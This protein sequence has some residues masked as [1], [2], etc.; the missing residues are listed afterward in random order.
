MSALSKLVAKLRDQRGVAAVEATVSV[1]FAVAFIG[2]GLAFTYTFLA[3]LW[4][5]NSAYEASI[6][7]S[8]SQPQFECEQ[9]LKKRLKGALTLGQL[10][11][12][13]LQ[14]SQQKVKT[15]IA[16]KTPAGLT[17]RIDDQRDLPLL[18]K[19]GVW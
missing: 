7:L 11:H 4:L 18:G 16:W 1:V 8:T 12:V 19:R 3:H 15:N 6:C 2:G 13:Q 5:K 9:A 14:R 17:L 10:E